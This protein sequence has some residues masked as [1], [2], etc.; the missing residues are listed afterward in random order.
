MLSCATTQWLGYLVQQLC[1]VC[2]VEHPLNIQMW[3]AA[4]VVGL[5]WV[6]VTEKTEG[7]QD[8]DVVQ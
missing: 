8:N 6:L 5:G 2:S 7:D 3:L 1:A 4:C